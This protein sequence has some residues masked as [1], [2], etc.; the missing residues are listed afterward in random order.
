MSKW[1]IQCRVVY[2]KCKLNTTLYN[3]TDA[4]FPNVISDA[5]NMQCSQYKS[6]EIEA[7]IKYMT[8]ILHF[9]ECFY[10]NMVDCSEDLHINL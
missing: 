8:T 2:N 7:H 3:M 10:W 1:G 6:K 5:F 4:G 9:T